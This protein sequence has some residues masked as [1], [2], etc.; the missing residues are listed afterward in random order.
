MKMG[1]LGPLEA[2]HGALWSDPSL[3]ATFGTPEGR[4]HR[5]HPERGSDAAALGRGDHPSVSAEE[6]R[7]VSGTFWASWTVQSIT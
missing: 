3:Q 4:A 6:A 5:R 7:R 1:Y 2:V